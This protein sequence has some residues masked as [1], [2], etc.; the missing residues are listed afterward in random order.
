MI[1]EHKKIKL[2]GGG[3]GTQNF[4][5]KTTEIMWHVLKNSA[6]FLIAQNI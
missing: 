4:V 5:E 2:W 6:N 3:E 1:F